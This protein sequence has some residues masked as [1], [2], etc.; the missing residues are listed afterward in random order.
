[1]NAKPSETKGVSKSALLGEL[2]HEVAEFG[3]DELFHRETY[4]VLGAG[5]GEEDAAFDDA[6]GGAA[7]DCG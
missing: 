4:G 3:E 2:F 5:G 6:G 1:M 7:Q